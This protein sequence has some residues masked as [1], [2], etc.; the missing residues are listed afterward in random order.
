VAPGPQGDVTGLLGVINSV[1]ARLDHGQLHT[2]T[3]L[4]VHAGFLGPT[5]N[6]GPNGRERAGI[7][8]EG[9]FGQ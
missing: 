3:P 8:P 7:G 9:P 4:G 6:E 2:A 5:P 1:G